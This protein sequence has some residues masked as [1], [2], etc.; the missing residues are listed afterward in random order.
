M[1]LIIL[2]GTFGKYCNSSSSVLDWALSDDSEFSF[3]LQVA[4][5]MANGG[6][7][8]TGEVLRIA[9][10]LTPGD[11]DSWFNEFYFLGE[12]IHAQAL[13]A[14]TTASAR[15]AYFRASTY[16][17]MSSFFLVGNASDPRLYG[18]WQQA[19]DDFDAA[20]ALQ[21]VPGVPFTV[22][23][24]GY[25]VPGYFWKSPTVSR[26]NPKVPTVIVGS[27]YDAPQ[28][29]SFHS[30]GLEVLSRGWNFVTYEGGGQTTTRRQQGVGFT[31]EWWKIVTPVVDYLSG[32]PEVDME[33]L[34][35]GGI[36]FG[37]ILAPVAASRE[38]RLKAVMSIDGLIDFQETVLN[39]IGSLADVFA[40]AN[41]TEF[42]AKVEELYPEL[43]TKMKWFLDQ[44]RWSF[45]TDSAYDF[46][47]QTAAYVVTP[48]AVAN[49]SAY[50]WVGKGE[51]DTLAGG[52]EDTLLDYY[53]SVG[54]HPGTLY[55]FPTN[56]GGG[57][58]SQTGAEQQLA[59]A[60]LDWLSTIFGNT[61][62]H[63]FSS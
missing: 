41:A 3:I 42:D 39:N 34:A 21:D 32:L 23:G 25:T 24:P 53:N 59:Q 7:A 20:I 49:I 57:S 43:P 16:Y 37:G 48:E 15:S 12:Q 9:S 61:T 45:N 11:F 4:L 1:E 8:S 58:H 28:Q 6:G 52:Q 38:P 10:Q 46:I 62:S 30:I 35:L 22:P 55:F 2:R 13:E 54:Q 14:K 63:S 5:S 18:P 47:N 26:H 60:V 29:D 56:V 36:S 27:G 50:G 40:S 33:N 31:P 17:R 44:G 51:N 19:L